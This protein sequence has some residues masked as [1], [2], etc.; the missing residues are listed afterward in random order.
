M[1]YDD[2]DRVILAR[3]P[4]GNEAFTFYDDNGKVSLRRMRYRQ[5]NGTFVTRT[6]EH[7]YASDEPRC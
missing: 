5:P 7:L 6:L 3:D 4:L 2:L 1:E